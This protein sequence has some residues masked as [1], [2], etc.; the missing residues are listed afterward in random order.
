[1]HSEPLLLVVALGLIFAVFALEIRAERLKEKNRRLKR[2]LES[3]RS[4]LG[5]DK[6]TI[7]R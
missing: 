6:E 3:L 1:M 4:W 7:S 5:W 2:E